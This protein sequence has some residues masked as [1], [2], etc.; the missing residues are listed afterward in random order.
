MPRR[1]L[2]ALLMLFAAPVLAQ[3]PAGTPPQ[4]PSAALRTGA[5]RV[6]A[7]LKGEAQ[8][9]EVFNAAF[10]AV[11]PAAQMQAAGAQLAAQYG[12]LQDLAGIDATSPISGTMHVRFER[13]TVH[14]NIAVEP[15]PP[16]HVQGLQLAG[17]DM[18]DDT[19]EA[20]LA[21]LRALPGQV[22]FA[23]ARL[24][25]PAPVITAGLEP[26]RALAVGSTFKLVILAELSRQVQAGQRRW[27]DVVPID[28]FSFA[29]GTLYSWPRGAPVTLHTLASLMISISDNTATDILLHALGRENVER[30]LTRMGLSD[31]ARNRPFISTLEAAAL[32]T[33][34]EAAFDAWRRADEAGRRRLLARDYAL[35]DASRLDAGL[36]AGGPQRIDSV[37]WF[38]SPADLARVMDW[39]RTNADDE[40]RAVMAIS[41]G[42]PA[43]ARGAQ[44]YVGFKGGS[45]PGVISLTYLI[46]TQAGGWHVVSAGW[47]N[48]AAPV[49]EARFAA[50]M[51]RVVQMLR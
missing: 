22:S 15:A 7:L 50:L 20:V 43:R 48:P 41:A 19:M 38:F 45:E 2:F 8:P 29:G 3:P 5:D 51:A 31:P 49:D 24:G 28:R 21:E 12:P 32:K 30:M 33:A 42:L 26:D 46:R 36:F 11:V 13:A 34:P 27:R 23:V 10:L 37:E 17:A 1:L 16:H 35:T 25:G 44:A 18:V 14:L 9:A 4:Q 47:N 40:A 39:L 6:V